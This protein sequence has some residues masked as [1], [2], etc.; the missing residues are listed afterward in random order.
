MKHTQFKCHLSGWGQEGGGPEG[1][2]RDAEEERL[3]SG[4]LK[5]AGTGRS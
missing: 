4:I 3:G 5:E 2:G 1:K